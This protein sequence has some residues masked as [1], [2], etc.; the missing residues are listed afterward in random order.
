[1]QVPRPVA[2]HLDDDAL[3]AERRD[4][5]SAL[6]DIAPERADVGHHQ[7]VAGAQGVDQ[8][9]EP[10]LPRLEDVGGG[11]TEPVDRHAEG[12]KIGPL[13]HDRRHVVAG[14]DQPDQPRALGLRLPPVAIALE[15]DEAL[16]AFGGGVRVPRVRLRIDHVD[17]AIPLRPYSIVPRPPERHGDDTIRA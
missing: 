14:H 4:R 15:L 5:P 12:R 8:A 6:G 2:E 11:V 1:M 7:H 17:H 16:R 13:L 3:A 10:L 9:C